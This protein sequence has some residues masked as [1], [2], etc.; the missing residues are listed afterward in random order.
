MTT[1]KND[2]MFLYYDEVAGRWSIF[3]L[4][5]A[6]ETGDKLEV[7]D[8]FAE[9]DGLWKEATVFYDD[10]NGCT[11]FIGQTNYDN[12]D[13]DGWQVRLAAGSLKRL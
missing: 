5:V 11:I 1:Q 8:D 10:L 7:L 4:G 12:S 13:I 2:G 3:P 6:L 9:E